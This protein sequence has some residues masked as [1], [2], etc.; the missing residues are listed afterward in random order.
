[1]R[2]S[3]KSSRH[4]HISK[5]RLNKKAKHIK[6]QRKHKTRKTRIVQRG[7]DF[8]ATIEAYY[9]GLNTEVNTYDIKVMLIYTYLNNPALSPDDKA[10][11]N[12]CMKIG[13]FKF[14]TQTISG[15][16]YSKTQ[17]FQ[18]I[19]S[20][21]GLGNVR[22]LVGLN[23]ITYIISL[24]D[25]N[26]TENRNWK[27]WLMTERISLPLPSALFNDAQMDKINETFDTNGKMTLDT[28]DNMFMSPG[29]TM[30]S[31]GKLRN[32]GGEDV[33]GTLGKGNK[34]T[35]PATATRATATRATRATR[36]TAPMPAAASNGWVHLP[37]RAAVAAPHELPLTHFWFKAWPDHGV[38]DIT[39]YRDFIKKIYNHIL[40][41]G[42][43]SII[44]CSAGVGRTGVVYITLNLLFEFGI[45]PNTEFPLTKSHVG[46]TIEKVLERIMLARQY[47]IKLVQTMEQFEFILRCFGLGEQFAAIEV[48]DKYIK[49]L[50]I[51]NPEQYKTD[52][53]K[54][55]ANMNKNRYR[56]ILPYDTGSNGVAMVTTLPTD[57][58][59]EGY[60]NA[61]FAPCILPDPTPLNWNC[62]EFI[63]SQCPIN[64]G[65]NILD[66][67]NMIRLH[68]IRRIIMVTGLVEGKTPKCDDYLT[69]NNNMIYNNEPVIVNDKFKLY[70][71]K[72]TA[73]GQIQEYTYI[74]LDSR[75]RTGSSSSA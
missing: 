40:E 71:Y 62:P 44:H 58:N 47:R 46:I 4:R 45:N 27:I 18:H 49:T 69:L 30:N 31:A 16:T 7:G 12:A 73:Y 17:I 26:R 14:A 8:T 35:T 34:S 65:N 59:P 48:K 32:D 33:Y 55:I 51:S 22:N 23:G 72:L 5:V 21:L 10:F 2:L 19:T 11:I 39:Q 20:L 43:R 9:E 37:Q 54:A 66:F 64:K 24:D 56:D 15:K 1:M 57:T 6:T 3:S 36:A 13:S 67:Q 52:T 68:N 75:G 60:I 53:A 28:L 50:Q 61:S 25:E 70:E 63:L 74:Q 38:P 29:Y 41:F 42:G